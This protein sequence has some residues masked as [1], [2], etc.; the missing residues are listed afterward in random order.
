MNLNPGSLPFLLKVGA[1]VLVSSFVT[2]LIFFF[3]ER[4]RFDHVDK[5]ELAEVMV[6]RVALSTTLHQTHFE[7]MVVSDCANLLD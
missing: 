1:W 3:F 6:L 5:P 4:D 2:G 7:V